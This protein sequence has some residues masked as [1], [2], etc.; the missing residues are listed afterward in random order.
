MYNYLLALHSATRWL[1]L[2]TLV[3]STIWAFRGWLAKKPF[4]SGVNKLRHWTAT[5]AHVQLMLGIALY[6]ISP[7]IRYFLDNFQVAV[8]QRAVRFF[9][10][11]HSLMMLVAVVLISIGSMKAKRKNTE[12]AKFKT[13]AIWFSIALLIILLNIPW[14]FSPLV[15]R[16]SFRGF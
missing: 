6:A 15:S 9:G 3:F 11:E 2:I 10:M 4:T 1:L 8:K 5:F 12:E 14:E 13:M 7:V 16:P